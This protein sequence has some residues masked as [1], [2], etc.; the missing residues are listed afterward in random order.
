MTI[1]QCF[2]ICHELCICSLKLELRAFD[3][4]N[5]N[6][7]CQTVDMLSLL[8]LDIR[9]VSM[10]VHKGESHKIEELFTMSV[11]SQ[12]L[13][14]S[15]ILALHLAELRVARILDYVCQ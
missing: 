9:E 2:F 12:Q 7:W 13:F 6:T 5:I 8:Q 15:L 10:V 3:V 1:F 4:R 14:H 11:A